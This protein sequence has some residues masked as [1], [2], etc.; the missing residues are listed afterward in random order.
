M[1][2]EV[3]KFGDR[4][5]WHCPASE[6]FKATNIKAVVLEQTKGGL[7]YIFTMRPIRK[8]WNNLSLRTAT[9]FPSDF[10]PK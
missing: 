9:I 8:G 2:K 1:K 7:L 5:T 3:L 6:E 4:G 10:T